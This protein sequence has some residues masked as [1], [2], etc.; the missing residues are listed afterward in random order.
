MTAVKMAE[1][2]NKFYPVS[3]LEGDGGVV[4]VPFLWNFLDKLQTSSLR[5][6]KSMSDLM[7]LLR[8]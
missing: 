8:L 7:F 5:L 3:S 1:A 6:E 4:N 2:I